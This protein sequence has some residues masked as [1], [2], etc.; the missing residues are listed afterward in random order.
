MKHYWPKSLH[1]QCEAVFH[2]I[3]SFYQGKVDNPQGIR[4]SRTWNLY[5]YESHR[6]VEF[7]KQREI[8]SLL[9]SDIIRNEMAVFLQEKLIY[10]VQHQQSRQTFET[11]LSALGKLQHAI[12]SYIALHSI[13]ATPLDTDSLRLE[14]Y[15][16]SKKLLHKTS[17]KYFNRAYP[18][19]V[20]LIRSIRN[21]TH[22]LQ[23]SLQY[24][25]GLRAEGVGSPDHKRFKN[26]LTVK[27][28]GGIGPDSVTGEPCG[29]VASVE[30]GGKG[31]VHFISVSTYN[32]L[33]NYIQIYGKLES[34]YDSYLASINLA[35]RE[36]GQYVAGRGTHALK[37]NFAQRRYIECVAH[38]MS[39]EE[40]MQQTSLE[41]SHFR[42]SETIA[43]TRGPR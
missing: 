11:I 32:Q 31:T 26:P 4:A 23:A 5:R 9:D 41:T 36:T 34:D 29:Y 38:N 39:H 40:S 14:Y 15:S 37:H 16:R 20:L 42:M 10:C 27:S 18:D 19:P 8:K 7:L 33:K 6:Y 22:R 35:A 21:S 12:N 2:S 13:E 30:K 25:G 17:R 24:E 28:L 43:Y 1:S 3:R